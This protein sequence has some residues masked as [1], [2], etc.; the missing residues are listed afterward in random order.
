MKSLRLD[1]VD[2]I[3]VAGIKWRPLRRPLGATAFGVAAFTAEPGEQLIEPHDE[4]GGGAGGHQEMYVVL[5]GRARFTVAGEELDAPQGT[6]V[7]VEVGEHREAAA[8]EPRTVVLAVGGVPGAAMPPSAFEYWFA[9]EPAYRAGD[10]TRAYEI[11]SEG[12]ADYPDHPSLNYQLACYLALGGRGDEA[13]E[14]LNKALAADADRV[15][16]W[17]AED[18]DLDSLRD[19]PDWP[20]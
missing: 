3:E 6:L 10:Y 7:L 16:E 19:R 20:L 18:S 9:A 14:H 5:S 13:I 1:E 4:S 2:A 17:G 15:R 8:V 12:L 11:A